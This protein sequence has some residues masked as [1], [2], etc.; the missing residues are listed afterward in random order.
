MD[1]HH[2]PGTAEPTVAA[3]A[4]Q[5]PAG[6]TVL[7]VAAGGGRH[8]LMFCERGCAVTAVD[9][10]CAALRALGDPRLEVVEA[11]LEGAAWPFGDRRWDAVV[12]TN[13]LWRP[14]LPHLA[15]A[16][17]GGGLLLYETFM[18]GNERFGRPRNPEFLLR[19][20]ELRA[21]ATEHGLEELAF[22]QGEVGAPPPAVRQRLLARRRAVT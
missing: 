13:Y 2:G 16:L 3:W 10:D 18:V 1:A 21:F 15:R 6:A 19:D 4:E 17:A 20:G 12:V 14:L 5:V 7:D 9:R 22:S 8:A 11:D